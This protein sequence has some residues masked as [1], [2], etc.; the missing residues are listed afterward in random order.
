MKRSIALFVAIISVGTIM[1]CGSNRAAVE[2]E[3]HPLAV[4]LSGATA[5]TGTSY[6]ESAGTSSI[7]LKIALYGD[8]DAQVIVSGSLYD[9]TNL[10]RGGAYD[11]TYEFTGEDSID[12]VLDGESGDVTLE[13]TDMS[14]NEGTESWDITVYYDGIPGGESQDYVMSLVDCNIGDA[15]TESPGCN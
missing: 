2:D 15:S 14:Y 11:G 13:I 1:G 3:P 12:V 8:G 5:A 6:W 10:E 7:A 4:F 9:S